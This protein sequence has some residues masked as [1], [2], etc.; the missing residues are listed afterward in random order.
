MKI[1]HAIETEDGEVTIQGTL[2]AKELALVLS[3]GLN[4]LYKQ[5]AIPFLPKEKAEEGNLQ[6]LSDTVQ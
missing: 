4:Y 2:E 1:N 6:P 3:V 5:G